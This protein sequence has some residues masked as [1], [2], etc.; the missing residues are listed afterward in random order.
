MYTQED[1]DNAKQVFEIPVYWEVSE[2]IE[3]YNTKR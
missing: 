1:I 2:I 3:D